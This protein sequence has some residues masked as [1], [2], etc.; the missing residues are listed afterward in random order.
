M[1]PAPDDARAASGEVRVERSR[2]MGIL[3]GLL[4]FTLGLAV[5]GVLVITGDARGPVYVI[6]ITIAFLG[7]GVVGVYLH[8]G[9]SPLPESPVWSP[10]TLRAVAAGLELPPVPVT[11]VLYGLAAVGIIG[12]VIVPLVLRK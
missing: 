6:A 9:A 5:A 11:A 4:A 7:V 12:N 3:G 1:T 2:A 10:V 8:R